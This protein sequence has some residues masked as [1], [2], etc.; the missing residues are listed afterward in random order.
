M[1]RKQHS[2]KKLRDGRS[3]P[4]VQARLS[5]AKT[6]RQRG[7]KTSKTT[8][9]RRRGNRG[10]AGRSRIGDVDARKWIRSVDEHEDYP[11]QTLVTDDPEVIRAWAEK[12]GA[13]P[14][15]VPGSEHQ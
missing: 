1:A 4:R 3:A 9:L 6:T 11:G 2:R 14:S 15:S 13:I 12:R 5:A 10:S 7:G 8:G